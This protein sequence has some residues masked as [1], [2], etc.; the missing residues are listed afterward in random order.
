MVI[1]EPLVHAMYFIW[2]GISSE[3]FRVFGKKCFELESHLTYLVILD[4]IN[5]IFFRVMEQA[6]VQNAW[7]FI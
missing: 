3:W 1:L 7:Y 6:I 5:M 4:R 2:T